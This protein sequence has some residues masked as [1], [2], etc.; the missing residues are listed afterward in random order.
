M[1]VGIY[2]EGRKVIRP[3]VW[4]K[5]RNPVVFAARGKCGGV[6]GGNGCL[7]WRREGQMES[8]DGR[9]RGSDLF[10]RQLVAAAG[11]AVAH[12]LP[13][14]YCPQIAPDAHIAKRSENCIVEAHRCFDVSGAKRDV[15]EHW[16]MWKS[17]ASVACRGLTFMARG[18]R[19]FR[20]RPSQLR[21]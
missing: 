21:D 2:Y 7:A 5:A 4:A 6:K 19:R 9:H 3:V 1:T 16:Q 20:A 14:A 15:V 11:K 18:G 12:R 13:R 17:S 8:G 10:D